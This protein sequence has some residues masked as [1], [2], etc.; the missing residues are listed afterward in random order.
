[1]KRSLILFAVFLGLIG[2]GS[3]QTERDI[4]ESAP[5]VDSLPSEVE[6]IDCPAYAG[7]SDIDDSLAEHVTD[8]HRFRELYLSA[9]P[10][11]QDDVPDIDFDGRDVIAVLAGRQSSGGHEVYVSDVSERDG[12]LDVGYTLVSPS[13]DCAV[14]TQITYPYCFVSLSKV[15]G[16]VHLSGQS[17]SACGLELE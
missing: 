13:S 8:A 15:Q 2:C 3:D 1:M 17:V 5:L 11:S 9:N 7:H 4:M 6:V 14:T 10:N 16:E 12:G